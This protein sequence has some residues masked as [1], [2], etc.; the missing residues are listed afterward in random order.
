MQGGS[1]QGIALT[2]Y[3]LITFLENQEKI[4]IYNETIA[5]ALDYVV[6]NVENLNDTYSLALVAYALQL[7][8][9]V[10]KDSILEKLNSK[11]N[12]K[13]DRKWW[14]KALPKSENSNPNSVN[15]E[16]TAYA[17]LSLL[18]NGTFTE[19]L[20]IL[21]WLLSQRNEQG[22]F[23]STQDTV[24]GL[25]ALAKYAERIPSAENNCQVVVTH[26]D[27]VDS[28]IDVNADNSIVYQTYEL[29]S[30]VRDVNIKAN[31]KG[32]ALVQLSYKYH[33]NSAGDSPRFNLKPAVD[34]SSTADHLKLTVCTR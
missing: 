1:G 4:P 3:T 22:G 19:G 9:H 20:P 18:K 21:K 14:S 24:V 23:E 28:K 11:A 16:M 15:T 12:A 25:Q 29:P 5:M 13:A 30:S 31:G 32:F 10:E 8:D 6:E 27:G 33:V 34:K 2:A 17:L 7:T 26:S